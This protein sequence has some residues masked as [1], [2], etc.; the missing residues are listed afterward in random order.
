MDLK[1]V[2]LKGEQ[3]AG[4]SKVEKTSSSGLTDTYTITLTDGTKR[5]FTLTN[6]NGIKSIVKTGTSGLTDTYTI[7]YTNGTT[8]TYTVKNGGSIQSIKKTGGDDTKNTFT[9]TQ[10]DGSTLTF[11][12]PREKQEIKNELVSDGYRKI[13]W[14][15]ITIATSAWNS[16]SKTATVSV[17]GVTAS[18]A[19]DVAPA[20]STY[21]AYT[22]AGIRASAQGSGTLTF[23]CEDVPTVDVVANVR[24]YS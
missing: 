6:G 17:S 21:D 10:F 15:I 13:T 2:M 23:K 20:E 18:N 19:V 3:G 14:T 4:V 22:T 1:V 9:L 7:T 24:I 8:Q 16:S 12:I 11:D 5:T